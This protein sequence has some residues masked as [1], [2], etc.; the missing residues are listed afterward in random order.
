MQIMLLIID[1]ILINS[2]IAR[3]HNNILVSFFNL[4]DGF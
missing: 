2:F 3:T 1:K 4:G